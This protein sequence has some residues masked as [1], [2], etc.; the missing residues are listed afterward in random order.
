VTQP[1]HFQPNQPQSLDLVSL[2]W[3]YARQTLR[4]T[5]LIE[6]LY[7]RIAT[8]PDPHIWI[9][10][11]PKDVVLAQARR[12]ESLS[13]EEATALPLFGIPFAVKDNI[14]LA[15]HPTTVACPDFAY[16]PSRSATVVDKLMA[17]GALL[18]GKTNLDQ[19][20]TG[21][22][23]VRS[24]Y[25]PVSNPFDP[26]FI[27]GGSSS[28][29]AVAVA[30]GLVSFALGTDTAGS[31]RVPAGY[32][33]IVGLKP[34]RGLISTAG[35]FPACRTLDCVSIFAL[36]V[37]DAAT[38]LRVCEGVDPADAYSRSRPSV[39][40]AA[41]LRY[42]VPRAEQLEFFGNEEYARL[43]A[44]GLALLETLGGTRVEID[45]APLAAVARLLYEGP[46]VA[47]RYAAV[48]EFFD[49]HPTAFLPVI[50]TI[51]DQARSYSAV[52]AFQA[53]YRLEE[54]RRDIAPL[55]DAIDCLA[56]PT[57][58][59]IYTIAEVEAEPLRLNSNLGR[60]TNFANLLDMC[61]LA[62]PNGFQSDGLPAGLTLL[63]TAFAEERLIRIGRD[64]QQRR[65]LP[66]GATGLSL[67]AT[68]K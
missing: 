23:G 26:Q 64:F 33:N 24:P 16:T 48:K 55:W 46:W 52:D 7:D 51:L 42:G 44:Q 8:H 20:A 37:D 62:L 39:A 13:P 47:E 9:S 54:L 17:A 18:L 63:A 11:L 35:V 19:F 41:S 28:G 31:G 12:L 22:V 66:L 6:I 59:T 29:S 1:T 57:A 21:L 65:G 4:P 49:S 56:L 3:A 25:G 53:Q 36:T 2:A 32:T 30:S 58:G 67:P 40:Q 43:Y 27:S 68:K 5:Q 50:R 60:Y 38:I 45:F 14:D 61:A 34:T 10:L 15:G